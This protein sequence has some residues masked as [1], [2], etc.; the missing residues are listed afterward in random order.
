LI[1]RS[2]IAQTLRSIA[3]AATFVT[4]AAT[5]AACADVPAAFGPT[6]AQAKLRASALTHLKL[7]A[8]QLPDVEEYLHYRSVDVSTIKELCRRWYPDVLADAPAKEGTHRALDD[9]KESVKELQYY[10]STVF[11]K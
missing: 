4:I 3:R 5:V 1:K 9:I 11:K 2:R 8:T 6:P 10:R 7:A